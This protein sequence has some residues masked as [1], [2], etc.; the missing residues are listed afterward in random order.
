MWTSIKKSWRQCSVMRSSQV[1]AMR[2]HFVA[3]IRI[4]LR[5]FMG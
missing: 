4:D 1:V 2:Y 5:K 3:T